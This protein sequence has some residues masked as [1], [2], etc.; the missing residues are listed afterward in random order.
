M[1]I[2]HCSIKIISRS[3]GRSA[4]AS[5]AYRSGEKLY[6]EETGITHDFTKKGGVIF[7]EILLPDNAP[8]KY[9]DRQ[10]LWN[11]V[12]K[13]ES[14]SDAQFAREVEVAIPVEI[15]DRKKQKEL[16]R[17]FI[18]ENFTSR[19]M[20]ADWALHDKGDGNPHA[21]ILLTV[22]GF[23]E[24]QEWDKKTRSVFANSRD[25]EGRPVYD[26]QK[27]FYDPK[28]REETQ[29][30]RIPQLDKNGEQKYR[31][32][33]GKGRE[34]LWERINIPTNDWNDK[35]N[36][37]IWRSSWAR[38]C[39]VYL[40]A[41]HRIDHRSYERQGIDK[42]PTIHEGVTARKIEAD[43]K[44]ADRTQI[45]REIKERNGLRDKIREIAGELTK[46]ITEKARVIYDRFRN[47]TRH[48]GHI[49]QA[50]GDDGY[51]GESAGRDR[52]ER[53]GYNRTEATDR[54]AN[55]TIR[56]I[57]DIKRAAGSTEQQI[58]E[59]DRIF[60]ELREIRERKERER[61]ERFKQLKE[62][63]AKNESGRS[64]RYVGGSAERDRAEGFHD[65]GIGETVVSG[66]KE[67]L[68]ET[69]DDI[70]QFLAD[71]NAQEESARAIED[72]SREIADDSAVRA[73][74]SSA[75][76]S[77]RE[78]EQQR[79]AAERSRRERKER[80]KAKR[81]REQEAKRSRNHGISL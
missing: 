80:E 23:T 59:T 63:R 16:V 51:V 53:S 15:T 27:P 29:Q 9:F 38:C 14:R 41:E 21:H 61:N 67:E 37:E 33:K 71:I 54:G 1:A 20:I 7:N 52:T 44:I 10:T 34:Y 28:N 79:L 74:D 8:V 11:D 78:A 22:R 64:S 50:R 42:E 81:E 35:S 73:G 26:P 75:E 55:G 57:S 56:R 47:F 48:S 3:G 24:E 69:A 46:A 2:Y 5:A 17:K 12:Q 18:Q 68:R 62:R 31:D 39:N 45:N 36:M 72:D 43:G 13:V 76:R 60:R 30:F 66:E 70:R 65:S 25:D 77:N 32:R 6:N 58:A 49:E 19:G 40:D 4:V